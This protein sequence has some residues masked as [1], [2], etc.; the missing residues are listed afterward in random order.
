MLPID[1]RQSRW[2]H[3]ERLKAAQQTLIRAHVARQRRARGALKRALDEFIQSGRT[4][5]EARHEFLVVAAQ[6]EDR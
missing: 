2:T 4:P 3:D 1:P 6:T 5:Q